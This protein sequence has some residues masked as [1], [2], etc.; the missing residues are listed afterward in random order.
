[1]TTTLSTGEPSTLGTYLHWTELLLGEDSEGAKFFRKKI[2]ESSKGEDEVVVAA[3]SQ[4][5]VL[6]AGFAKKESERRSKDER[7]PNPRT[8]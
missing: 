3:E 4:M 8:P 6:I 5:M 1:M 7:L 2:A